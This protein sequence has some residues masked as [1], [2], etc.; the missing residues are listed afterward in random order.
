MQIDHEAFENTMTEL[1]AMYDEAE[2]LGGIT[3]CE[4]CFAC[5]TAYL[6]YLCMETYYEKVSGIL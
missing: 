6:S 5:L 1:N 4:S 3:Y 2:K